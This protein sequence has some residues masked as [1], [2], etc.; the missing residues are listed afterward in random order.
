[1]TLNYHN[2]RGSLTDPIIGMILI[3]S[4]VLTIFA[5]VT[6]WNQFADQIE[7]STADSVANETISEDLVALTSYYTWFD[8]GVPLLV[9]GLLLV[10]LITALKSGA[11]YIYSVVSVISWTIVVFVSWVLKEIFDEYASY[12]PTMAAQYP[13]INIIMTNISIIAVIWAALISIVMFAQ[14]KSGDSDINSSL[15]QYYG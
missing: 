1:M 9:V 6:F 2:K 7:V 5:V 15:S 13:I 4:V 14:N 10:S 3:L 12:F 8:W 11:S